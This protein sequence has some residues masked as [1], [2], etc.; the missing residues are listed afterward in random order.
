M[1]E[2]V[3][4]NEMAGTNN[5]IEYLHAAMLWNIFESSSDTANIATTDI[6][7][8]FYEDLNKYLGKNYCKLFLV[9]S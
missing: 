6:L 3:Q 9:F 2:A 7:Q 8:Q 4:I 5:F 1:P